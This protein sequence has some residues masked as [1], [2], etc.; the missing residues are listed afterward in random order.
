MPLRAKWTRVPI[1]HTATSTSV[2][3]RSSHCAAS[4]DGS[5]NVVIAF[6]E[7]KP[8][9]P[10]EADIVTV[11]VVTGVTTVA[12]STADGPSKRVGAAWTAANGN[13][14]AWGGR[15]GKDM[16]TFTD[17]Q[18]EL[19]KLD[20]STKKWSTVSTTGS[21]PESRSFHV[22][23]TTQDQTTLFVHAGC[24]AKGRLTTLHAL[25]LKTLEWQQKQS[26]PEPGRGGT[27]LTAFFNSSLLAR[28]GGFAGKELDGLDLYDV[29]E[30]K[31]ASVETSSRQ[32][33]GSLPG[34]RSVH[35]FIAIDDETILVPKD[36]K[37]PAGRVIAL[38]TAG[39]RDPAPAELGH[40]GSGFFHD[41]VWALTA[42]TD[43]RLSFSTKF[44]WLKLEPIEGAETPEPR[45]W[46]AS[47]RVGR[48]KV[49]IHGGLNADNKR[50]DDAWV[51]QVVD[52]A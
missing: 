46:F 47:T 12:E 6:G 18:N 10:V 35:S 21:K 19:W 3:A 14:Y 40:D 37:H 51:L 31:W 7:H 50:L 24:P 28:F 5:N 38:M 26:A 1:P 45:G 4:V 11:D 23:T 44:S 48:D 27:V 41:D 17:E 16:A 32:S 2:L 42:P 49:F 36:D 33:D 43:E 25:S 20:G 30:D 39:E 52:E 22:M 15:G 8:R 13:L 34:K 9:E 29:A